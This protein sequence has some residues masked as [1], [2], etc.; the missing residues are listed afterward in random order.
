M[1]HNW[2]FY[3][4]DLGTKMSRETETDRRIAVVGLGYVGLPVATAFARSGAPVVAFD[5]SEQRIAELRAG[6]DR[7]REVVPADLSYSG[8]VSP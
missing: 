5:I 7:T 1:W 2:L 3:L 6:Y 8:F 4:N